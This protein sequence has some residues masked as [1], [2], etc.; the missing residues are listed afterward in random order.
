MAASAV[1]NA[2]MPVEDHSRYGREVGDGAWKYEITPLE[3]GTIHAG[4]SI[5]YNKSGPSVTAHSDVN[6]PCDNPDLIAAAL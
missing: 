6:A 5:E 1:E 3:S 4:H 2:F